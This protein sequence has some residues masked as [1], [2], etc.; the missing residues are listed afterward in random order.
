P[1]ERAGEM[2]PV[3][4]LRPG[5]YRV[6]LFA[7]GHP[8]TIT[9]EWTGPTTTL[10]FDTPL[11]A[12]VAMD[13]AYAVNGGARAAVPQD[14]APGT[15][16]ASAIRWDPASAPAPYR[17]RGCFSREPVSWRTC[18]RRFPSLD[19]TMEPQP[20]GGG[21]GGTGGDPS[22]RATRG[23]TAFAEVLGVVTGELMVWTIRYRP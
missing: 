19:A 22:P 3:G 12:R 15:V 8:V 2:G 6:Y 16:T 11:D 9:I 17:L 18:D 20:L 21:G 7:D 1:A 10:E 13:R 5:T 4:I 14:G 23:F